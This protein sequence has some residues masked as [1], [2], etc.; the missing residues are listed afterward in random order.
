MKGRR[1]PFLCATQCLCGTSFSR[2]RWLW[3]FSTGLLWINSGIPM[4]FILRLCGHIPWIGWC[5]LW[6]CSWLASHGVWAAP[7]IPKNIMRLQ[8]TAVGNPPLP[9]LRVSCTYHNG[10]W[11]TKLKDLRTRRNCRN[12]IGSTWE[13]TVKSSMTVKVYSFTQMYIGG[14]I[15]SFRFL[16]SIDPTFFWL[17]WFGERN[18]SLRGQLTNKHIQILNCLWHCYKKITVVHGALLLYSGHWCFF[19]TFFHQQ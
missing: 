19:I 1:L 12:T 14:S 7:K 13:Y 9:E 6:P 4:K 18:H 10:W 11:T 8:S 5:S 17:C 15:L 3:P 2:C 16:N